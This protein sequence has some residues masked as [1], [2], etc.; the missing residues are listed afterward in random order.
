[1]RF[2]EQLNEVLCAELV[3]TANKRM[4]EFEEAMSSPFKS[5]FHAI[6]SAKHNNNAPKKE[7]A[8]AAAASPETR[9]RP[10]APPATQPREASLVPQA[11][12]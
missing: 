12:A 3:G 5:S 6:N 1:M 4:S 10:L 2:V 11:E 9:T 7:K 8:E